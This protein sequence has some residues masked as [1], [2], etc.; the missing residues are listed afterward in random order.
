MESLG[1]LALLKASKKTCPYATSM[2]QLVGSSYVEDSITAM[3]AEFMIP[4]YGWTATESHSGVSITLCE[5]NV[6]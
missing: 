5:N 2:G 4:L 3:T 6:K 1:L